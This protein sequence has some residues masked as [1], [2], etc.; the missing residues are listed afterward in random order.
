MPDPGQQGRTEC[1]D[2]DT[3]EAFIHADQFEATRSRVA[4][5]A[6][7]HELVD[8]ADA[9][10]DAAIADLFN[11]IRDSVRASL[12]CSPVAGKDRQ[13]ERLPPKWVEEA[14]NRVRALLQVE[15]VPKHDSSS[16]AWQLACEIVDSI[17][18][19]RLGLGPRLPAAQRPGWTRRPLID[20]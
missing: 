17:V 1:P 16:S 8:S 13:E 2:L 12:A 4:D 18:A 10:S 19:A 6:E 11:E 5:W 14:T 3:V 15:T 20:C 7:A 9:L